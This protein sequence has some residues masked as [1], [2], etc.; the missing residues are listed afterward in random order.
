MKIKSNVEFNMRI[1][2]AHKTAGKDSNKVVIGGSAPEYVLVPA[3][4]SVELGDEAWKKFDK[5]AQPYLASGA[6]TMVVAPALTAEEVA[7]KEA[8]EEAAAEAT[9]ARLAEKKKRKTKKED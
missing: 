3:G 6:M 4:A 7:A 5:A 9:L 1:M 2:A 8:A